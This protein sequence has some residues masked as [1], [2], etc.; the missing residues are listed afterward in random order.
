M[1]GPVLLG[2]QNPVPSGTRLPYYREPGL[3]ISICFHLWIQAPSN[4]SNLESFGFLLTGPAFREPSRKRGLRVRHTTAKAL[5]KGTLLCDRALA[6]SLFHEHM[7]NSTP[8]AAPDLRR[9]S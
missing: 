7:R 3:L 8:D 4:E 1:S 9:A 5:L 2:T 6:P